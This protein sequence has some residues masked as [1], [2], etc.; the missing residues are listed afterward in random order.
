MGIAQPAVFCS[1]THPKRVDGQAL[2]FHRVSN[3]SV[4]HRLGCVS[5]CLNFGLLLD[6]L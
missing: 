3:E 4:W 6:L 5:I 1:R 2:I